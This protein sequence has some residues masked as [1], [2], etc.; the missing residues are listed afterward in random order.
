MALKTPEN[1]AI[2]LK[3]LLSNTVYVF[4]DA[5]RGQS[6]VNSLKLGFL[7]RFVTQLSK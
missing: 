6:K 5:F 3:V 1:V 4:G 2:G 7:F